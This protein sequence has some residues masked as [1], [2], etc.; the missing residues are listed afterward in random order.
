MAWERTAIG[1]LAVGALIL[2][3]RHEPVVASR[4]II[5][6]ASVLIAVAVCWIGRRRA[7]HMNRSSPT[8]VRLVGLLTVILAVALVSVM[9]TAA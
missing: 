4:V 8:S 2:V 5:A 1:F 6:V 7:L 9:L 3:P